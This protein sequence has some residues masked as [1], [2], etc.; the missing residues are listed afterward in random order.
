MMD[1]DTRNNIGPGFFRSIVENAPEVIVRYDSSMRC[2]YANPAIERVLGIPPEMVVGLSIEDMHWPRKLISFYKVSLKKV[3]DTR[4]EK[5]IEYEIPTPEGLKYRRAHLTPELDSDGSVKTV[6]SVAVDITPRKQTEVAL[7]VSEERL[8]KLYANMEALKEQEKAEIARH[9]HDDLG[10][11]MMAL[12]MDLCWLKE[13]MNRKQTVLID[14]TV[15]DIKLLDELIASVKRMNEE[16]RPSLL[17]HVGLE[18]AMEW[19]IEGFKNRSGI[20]CM[21]EVDL[22]GTSPS[23]GV[24]LAVFRILQE[25]LNNIS[26]HSR[27]TEAR[28]RLIVY[29]RAMELEISDNG[30]GITKKQLSKQNSFGI[31]GIRERIQA[32]KGEIKIGPGL[33]SGTAVKISIPSA[34]L[35]ES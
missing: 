12:K 11:K 24:D 30:I 31:Q 23:K 32:L 6:L 33:G 28:V 25:A 18:A 1:P 3:F 35:T 34:V 5:V 17:E 13:K 4:R 2:T 20:R 27:A 9:I 7:K 15:E 29:D 21:L 22:K 10:Q 14:K 19:L 16:L 26:Y 8:R